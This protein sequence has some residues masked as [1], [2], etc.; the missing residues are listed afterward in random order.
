MFYNISMVTPLGTRKGT[1]EVEIENGTVNGCL[2]IFSNRNQFKGKI[3][4]NNH[5][6]LT[7]R[8]KTLVKEHLYTAQGCITSEELFLKLHANGR[9]YSLTGVVSK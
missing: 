2:T 4:D 8:F 9:E 7:G 3:D 1:M 6:E 5:C